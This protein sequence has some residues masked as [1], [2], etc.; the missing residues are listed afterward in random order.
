MN[1]HCHR[2][3]E[4]GFALIIVMIVIFSLAI[5]AG[6]FAFSMKVESRLAANNNSEGEMQW[7]GR[8]GVELARF[9]LSESFNR[10]KPASLNQ[11]WAGGPGDLTETNG[12]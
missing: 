7:L 3:Q 12:P 9:V 11:I 1:C 5:L 2:R 6:G 10:P 4:R 8:S